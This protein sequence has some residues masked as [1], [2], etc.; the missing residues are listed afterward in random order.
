MIWR[1]QSH[2]LLERLL[3]IT[4][5]WRRNTTT[6]PHGP[7]MQLVLAPLFL[8]DTVALSCE[9]SH[10]QAIHKRPHHGVRS[11][12]GSMNHSACLRVPYEAFAACRM[13]GG[14]I[15]GPP[16]RLLVPKVHV[17]FTISP[18]DLMKYQRGAHSRT[19]TSHPPF[20][21]LL[22]EM[23]LSQTNQIF[24]AECYSPISSLWTTL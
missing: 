11:T 12:H 15:I 22:S 4:G 2:R 5:A 10:H 24:P 18:G 8:G 17:S 23:P 7:A 16:K 6:D 13:Q 20:S 3:A 21:F 1:S 19:S 14:V 9:T